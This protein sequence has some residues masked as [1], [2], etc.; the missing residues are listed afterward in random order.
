V[1]S[2]AG[3]SVHEFATSANGTLTAVVPKGTIR[4]SLAE[5]TG[6]DLRGLGLLLAKDHRETELRCVAGVFKITD[7]TLATERFV[8][9]TDPVLI[10]GDGRIQFATE[11]LDLHLGGEP[12]S[13]RLFHFRSPVAIKGTLAHPSIGIEAHHFEMVDSGKAKDVDCASLIAS[14]ESAAVMPAA[15]V[16]R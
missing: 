9:D 15:A 16:F 3:V 12:K 1:A 11:S 13:L 2:G 14:A 8:A 5:L 4:D 7:G 10:T 6:M